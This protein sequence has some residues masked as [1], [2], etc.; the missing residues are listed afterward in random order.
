MLPMLILKLQ[1]NGRLEG[2]GAQTTNGCE[3]VQSG[4]ISHESLISEWSAVS[5][6]P[7]LG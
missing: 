7:C 6:I 3:E 1:L 4:I 2:K 5:V